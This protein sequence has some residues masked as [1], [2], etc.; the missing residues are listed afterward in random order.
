MLAPFLK[1]SSSGTY[2]YVRLRE[3]GSFIGTRLLEWILVAVYAPRLSVLCHVCS[4]L[5]FLLVWVQQVCRQCATCVIWEPPNRLEQKH[6][7]TTNSAWFHCIAPVADC[8]A[9]SAGLSLSSIIA[10]SSPLYSYLKNNVLVRGNNKSIFRVEIFHSD[11]IVVVLSSIRWKTVN[12]FI[13]FFSEEIREFFLALSVYHANRVLI[14]H[15]TETMDHQSS[16]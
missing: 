1:T 4:R 16:H 13:C 5:D 11:G 15:S 3:F 7:G 6:L 12:V 8:R 9:L 2:G 10:Q 14:Y